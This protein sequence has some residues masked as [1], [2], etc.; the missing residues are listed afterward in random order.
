MTEWEELV[1]D[2]QTAPTTFPTGT[3]TPHAEGTYSGVVRSH[4]GWP[5]IISQ[6]GLAESV[7]VVA[8]AH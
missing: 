3:A 6:I 8:A 2:A 5:S 4:V 1:L 7:S